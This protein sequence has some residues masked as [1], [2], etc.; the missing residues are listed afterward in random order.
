MPTIDLE[1]PATVAGIPCI[2]RVTHYDPGDPGRLYGH[3]DDQYPPEPAELDWTIL[4]G[5]GRP[6]P[7]LE[8]KMDDQD[9]DRIGSA[10]LRAIDSLALIG[11]DFDESYLSAEDL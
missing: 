10:L 8:R 7:W 4:D 9:I 11:P 5:R 6:A 3:P 1:I 2:A